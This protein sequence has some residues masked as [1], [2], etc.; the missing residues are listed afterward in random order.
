MASVT[1]ATTFLILGLATV[2]VRRTTTLVLP[3]SSRT[4]NVLGLRDPKA[5]LKQKRGDRKLRGPSRLNAKLLHEV[6]KS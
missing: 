5:K 6:S 2:Q 4:G 3:A 1:A